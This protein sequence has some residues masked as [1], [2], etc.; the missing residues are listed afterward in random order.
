[1]FTDVHFLDF[2]RSNPSIA[3]FFTLAVGF[4][5]GKVRIKSFSLGSVTSVL[6]VGVVVGQ[7]DITINDPAKT[8]FFLLFLFAIGYSVGP[9]FF[10]GLHSDGLPQ[11]GFAVLQCL[12]SLGA[13]WLCAVIMGYDASQAAGLLAGS[14]TMSAALGAASDTM[15]QISSSGV[16]M[17]S[18]SVCY[19]VTYI[20]GTAGSAWII[21]WLGPK[22][23]G[24]VDKVR[25]DARA[26]EQKL[27]R[28]MTLARG[29][30]P[31]ARAI[32]FRAFSADNEWFDGRHTVR[33][34]E[35]MM[36]AQQRRIFV[37]RIRHRGVV[38]DAEPRMFIS[39]GDVLVVSGRRRFVIE[40]E[41]WIGHEVEDADLINFPVMTM[42]VVVNRRGAAGKR[43]EELLAQEY[44]HGVGI[45][46]LTRANVA[47]PVY[48]GTKLDVGDRVELT[49]IRSDV[50]SAAP[51]VGFRDMPTEK[52]SISLIGAAITIGA[53][54]FGWVLAARI[55][56]IPLSLT[57]S[58]GVLIA[59]LVC[60]WL[61]SR[62]PVLGGIPESAVWLMNNLG[63][64]TFI[65][66]VGIS[67][68]PSFIS[69]FEQVGWTLLLVGVVATSLPLILGVLTGRYLF[70][71]NSALTL[72]C[73]AG[74]RT[75]TAALGAVEEVLDSNVPAMGY[76]ITYAIGNTLLII[77]GVVIVLLMH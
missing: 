6:L 2:I 10:R 28:D 53:L 71:F 57:V 36:A 73:A 1:M 49:G 51:N 76:T 62:K 3:V 52:S 59:G 25:A 29:F 24:G 9:Q 14:Q 45:R 66:I 64:N 58:G 74:A 5:L 48:G 77:W 43:I 38:R 65:A 72:G 16:D 32:V 15:Q 40:E 12:F 18:M 30:D 35:Q 34:F 23:L 70:K 20:F 42:P 21:S 17:S 26:L 37:E 56:A 13:V 7:L 54:L 46:S 31:A 41:T 60:G 22:M 33:E 4:M 44:M 39:R 75:T 27:G 63:L 61:R 68:G 19:A 11:V 8:L 47:I 69:G 67:T 50:E 55:G